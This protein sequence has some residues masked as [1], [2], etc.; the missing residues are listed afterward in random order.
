M[1]KNISVTDAIKTHRYYFLKMV[2][3]LFCGIYFFHEIGSDY[4]AGSYFAATFDVVV[5]LISVY[6]FLKCDKEADYWKSY[7][8][9]ADK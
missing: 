2:L 7:I 6:N 4:A 3:N 5:F 1:T 9:K 8:P